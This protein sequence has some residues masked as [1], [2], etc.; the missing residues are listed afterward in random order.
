M[1]RDALSVPREYIATDSM[2]GFYVLAGPD[3]KN[4]SEQPVTIGSVGDRMVEIVSGL[5][6]GDSLLPL[7]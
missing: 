6:L 1:A 4:A 7:N 3:A 5:S 2:G